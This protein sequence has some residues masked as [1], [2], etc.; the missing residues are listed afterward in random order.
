LDFDGARGW[1]FFCSQSLE[2]G[3]FSSSIDSQKSEAL[4]LAKAEGE[5]LYSA[6]GGARVARTRA[7]HVY[8]PESI[9]FNLESVI[10]SLLDSGGFFQ[11]ISIHVIHLSRLGEALL[12]AV[13]VALINLLSKAHLNDEDHEP[14][15][16]EMAH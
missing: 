14:P 9:N 7:S 6:E 11:N 8:F 15:E 1:F 12:G 3:R 13:D 16:Y 2:G 5:V 4:S 10:C